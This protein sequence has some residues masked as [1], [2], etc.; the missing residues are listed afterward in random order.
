MA[1]VTHV[2]D[3]ESGTG[4][5]FTTN[6]TAVQSGSYARTGSYSLA[7]TATSVGSD[8]YVRIPLN[9]TYPPGSVIT[10]AAWVMSPSGAD[11]YRWNIQEWSGGYRG[12]AY[13]ASAAV[14]LDAGVWT[15]VTGTGTLFTDWAGSTSLILR[16]IGVPGAWSTGDTLYLDDLYVESGEVGPN[17]RLWDE[18]CHPGGLEASFTFDGLVI[19]DKT[20]FDAYVLKQIAGIFD[21][22]QVRPVEVALPE[23]PGVYMPEMYY[24]SRTITLTGYIRAGNV[25]KLRAMEYDLKSAILGSQQEQTLLISSPLYPQNY[26]IECRG[27][28]CSINERLLAGDIRAEFSVTLVA[29]DPRILGSTLRTYTTNFTASA[30][31]SITWAN[32]PNYGSWFAYPQ[33]RLFE[34]AGLAWSVTGARV[35]W[36]PQNVL[37]IGVEYNGA[38]LAGGAGAYREFDTWGGVR[39]YDAA[40]TSYMNVAVN[41][42]M[43][44]PLVIPPSDWSPSKSG[45][46][47]TGLGVYCSAETNDVRAQIRWKDT[48]L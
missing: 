46:T 32:L 28:G 36:I 16:P 8:C 40:G 48:Y 41:K 3:F 24:G 44:Y 34:N 20:V 6:C 11:T 47:S 5:L 21:F 12:T 19:N 39:L 22:P 29:S 7:I 18:Q 35:S 25:A 27:M 23:R 45:E 30:T 26:T 37:G 43:S 2:Q 31:N 4:T 15:R 1:V 14:S 38:A 9:G 13:N 33:V 10:W 17:G 42:T